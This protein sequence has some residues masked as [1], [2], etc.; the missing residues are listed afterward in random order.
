MLCYDPTISVSHLCTTH[1]KSTNTNVK[2]LVQKYTAR[3][4]SPVP[5]G[6]GGGG[7]GGREAGK[8]CRGSIT[9]HTRY[10]IV[11]VHHYL[12]TVQINHFRPTQVTLQNK[13]SVSDL[14]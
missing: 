13:V 14:V 10:V 1:C 11:C 7:G 12:S 8:N 9:S 4:K 5:L 3:E 2:N 6:G